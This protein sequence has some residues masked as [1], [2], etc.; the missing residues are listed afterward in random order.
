MLRRIFKPKRDE[1]TGDWRKLHND[2]SNYFYSSPNVIG[3]I[4]SRRMGL[5]RYAACMILIGIHVE[6]SLGSLKEK[7]TRKT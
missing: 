6:I 1:V 7:T 3:F 4:K 5:V 2:E